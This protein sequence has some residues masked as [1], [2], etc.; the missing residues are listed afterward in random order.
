MDPHELLAAL[1]DLAEGLG[2]EIR[3]A[4]PGTG[5]SALI[6]LKGKEM[7]FLDPIAPVADQTSVVA[8]AL[9]GRSE[10]ENRFLPPEIRRQLDEAQE[11]K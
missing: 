10:L 3:R 11:E 5:S 8:E 6:R 4:P 2:I 9:A 7:L 1:I